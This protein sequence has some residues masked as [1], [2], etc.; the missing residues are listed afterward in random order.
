VS[1]RK[2]TPNQRR[3][4]LERDGHACRYCGAVG[5]NLEVDHI[6]PVVHGGPNEQWNLVA[7]CWSCNNRKSDLMWGVGAPMPDFVAV[8]YRR[9]AEHREEERW[10]DEVMRPFMVWFGV[11]QGVPSCICRYE[12]KR[13]FRSVPVE[14]IRVIVA[15]AAIDEAPGYNHRYRVWRLTSKRCWKLARQRRRIAAPAVA[16]EAVR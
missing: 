6:T 10:L 8:A 4:I 16:G 2:A 14:D 5:D 9:M 1:R 11:G 13:V 12:M 15:Q 7:A 3:A